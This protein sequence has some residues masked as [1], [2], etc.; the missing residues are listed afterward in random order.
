MTY[1]WFQ[2]SINST[3]PI[4]TRYTT[5]TPNELAS[6]VTR[7]HEHGARVFFRPCIDPDWSYS[8][9]WNTWRGEI[10]AHFNASSWATWFSYYTPFVVAQ[11]SLAQT[12][13]VDMFAVGMEYEAASAQEDHWRNVVAQVRGVYS[14]GPVTYCANHG[15]AHRVLWWD[16]VDEISVDAYYTLAAGEERP[17]MAQLVASWQPITAELSQL[18]QAY[19]NKPITFAEIGYCSVTGA[20]VNPANNC[21]NETMLNTT[22]QRNLYEAFFLG[23]YPQP[24]LKGV[25]WWAW[26]TDPANGGV[27]DA[28]FTPH[29]KPAEEVMKFWFVT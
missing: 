4:Y 16:A 21:G 5:P 19:S 13:G 7:A 3:G 22:A 14:L 11:A 8:T 9:N 24:W 10:G 29:G 18:S 15:N 28:S 25:F 26:A 20:N 12:L 27:K 6:I 1:C 17:S 2:R 23:V